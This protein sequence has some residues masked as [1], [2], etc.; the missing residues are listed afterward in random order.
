[1]NSSP[2]ITHEPADLVTRLVH[3][4]LFERYR[5]AFRYN[6]LHCASCATTPPAQ[7]QRELFFERCASPCRSAVAVHP[8]LRANP[9][10][11]QGSLQTE[12]ARQ[13]LEDGCTGDLRAARH[14]FDKLPS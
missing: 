14:W 9:H 4:D 3:S 6:R 10:Q 13:M 7:H 5:E 1:M 12:D 8:P 2:S 11:R